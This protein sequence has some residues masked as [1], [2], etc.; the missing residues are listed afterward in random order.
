[1]KLQI[2]GMIKNWEFTFKNG[3]I[4]VRGSFFKKVAEE[5]LQWNILQCLRKLNTNVK[6]LFFFYGFPKLPV[7]VVGGLA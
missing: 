6:L 4:K 2:R 3:Q 1:M 7:F 5:V